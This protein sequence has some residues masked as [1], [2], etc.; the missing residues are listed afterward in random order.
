M[1]G[2]CAIGLLGSTLLSEDYGSI[3][4]QI[5]RVWFHM[6][7]WR[8]RICPNASRTQRRRIYTHRDN[9]IRDNPVPH[10]GGGASRPFVDSLMFCL[11]TAE[12]LLKYILKY[13]LEYIP[14]YIYEYIPNMFPNI[15]PNVSPN[16]YKNI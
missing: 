6:V 14:E 13:V 4:P 9:Q 7:A 3:A 12:I 10:K 5:R 16:I 15:S 2:R 1:I 8:P 11:A